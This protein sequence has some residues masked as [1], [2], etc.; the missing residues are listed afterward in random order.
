MLIGK[1]CVIVESTM[2]SI[3]GLKGKIIDET[4]NMIRIES[5][6]KRIYIPKICVNMLVNGNIIYGKDIMKRPV[7]RVYRR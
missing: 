3:V 7:D 2:N 5:A 1:D 4:K 6:G